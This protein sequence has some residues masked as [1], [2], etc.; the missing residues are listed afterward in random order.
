[1]IIPLVRLTRPYYCLPL[2][3]GLL[4]ITTY[5]T[6]GRR[7]IL[8]G[9]L[10]PAFLAL[11]SVLSAAYLLN[12]FCDI[13]AD[14]VNHP[15]RVLPSK[16]LAPAV[17]LI[18]SVCL[19]VLGLALASFCGWGFFLLLTL[20]AMGLAAYDVFSKRLGMF[21]PIVVALLTTSLY[22]LAFTLSDPVV[23]PRLYVLWIHPVWLL[24]T[25]L[26]Y[27]MLKDIRDIRGDSLAGVRCGAEHR[28]RT[29]F[30]RLARTI[31]LAASLLTL[32]PYALGL[33]GT[34]YLLSSLVAIGLVLLSL[35]KSA[36]PALP[37][38]YGSVF[39]IAAGSWVD[40]W[41]YGP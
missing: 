36:V 25:T 40:L 35:R 4:V 7:S 23:T 22:P 30:M 5:V 39:V 17:A 9:S 27:E 13:H 10:V 15:R 34:V 26:G 1:M 32:L 6:G 37:Y 8:D 19:F 28:A 18:A 20:V 21:K 31:L 41:V 11:Y 16:Q 12:D 38:I 14:A 2:S 29:G 24:A 3:A 33:C